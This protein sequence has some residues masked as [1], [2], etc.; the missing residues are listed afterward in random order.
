VGIGGIV[1]SAQS[2]RGRGERRDNAPLLRGVG[3]GGA[4]GLKAESST[5][6]RNRLPSRRYDL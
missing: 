6:E 5:P 4:P 1:V 3:A 2:Q